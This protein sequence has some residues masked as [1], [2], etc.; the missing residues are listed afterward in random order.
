MFP[1]SS[2]FG[3]TPI[4]LLCGAAFSS[5][6]VLPSPLRWCCLLLL[7]GAAF[8]RLPSVVLPFLLETNEVFRLLLLRSGAAP[9]HHTSSLLLLLVLLS[10][11][12]WCCPFLSALGW[13]F[14]SPPLPFGWWCFPASLLSGCVTLHPPFICLILLSLLLWRWCNMC[15]STGSSH[16]FEF[17]NAN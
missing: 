5:S 4:L 6:V 3:C 14:S 11:L 8:L 7:G 17:N 9:L 13:C 1:P 2:L 10:P 16:L 12:G 15:C